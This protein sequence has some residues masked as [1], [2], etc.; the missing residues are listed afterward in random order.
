[1]ESSREKRV[2]VD[3]TDFAILKGIHDED[4]PLWKNRIHQRLDE[5]ADALPV[6]YDGVE[7]VVDG[8]PA[9]VTAT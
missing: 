5:R 8:F 4:H 3:D 2:D 9:A 1:L 7:A 6:T